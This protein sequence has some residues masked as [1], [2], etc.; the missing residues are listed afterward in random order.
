MAE[1]VYEQLPVGA[2]ME[3]DRV[4]QVKSAISRLDWGALRD[5]AILV[6]MMM[7]DDRIYADLNT[8][9]AGLLSSS[10]IVEPGP[11]ANKRARAAADDL[12]E[13]W[14]H[15]FSPSSLWSLHA[16]GTMLG[17]GI[18]QL[19]YSTVDGQ[20]RPRLQV[21]HPQFLY[22]QWSTK[23]YHLATANAG[24]IELPRVDENLHRDGQWVIYTPYG[25][26]LGYMRAALRYLAMPW[27]I[28]QWAYRDWARYSEVHGMP[29]RVAQTPSEF[30]I[31]PRKKFL[32]DISNL[33][34]ETALEAPKNKDGSAFD[35]KLVEAMG[36]SV[37]CF[38]RLLERCEKSIGIGLLGQDSSGRAQGGSLAQFK[39]DIR[40]DIVE[41][42][43]KR[44]MSTL[45]DQA[46]YWYTVHNDG[47]PLNVPTPHLDVAPPDDELEES[48]AL[49]NLFQA[50]QAGINTGLPIDWF[51]IL[52]TNGVPI[53]DDLA[54]Q[55][56]PPAVQIAQGGTPGEEPSSG[57]EP[58]APGG[59]KKGAA[60]PEPGTEGTAKKAQPAE[61]ALR[62]IGLT[63]TCIQLGRVTTKDSPPAGRCLF[64]GLPVTVENERGSI[65]R[66]GDLDG[67]QTVMKHHYGYLEEHLGADGEEVDC[68][69]GPNED[70]GWAYVIRQRDPSTGNYDEDKV[71]LG[72][73]SEAEAKDAYMQQYND[74]RFYGGMQ[75]MTMAE[76]K[77]K[78]KARKSRPGPIRLSE[79]VQLAE[80]ARPAF[81]TKRLAMYKGVNTSG[82][83]A[84]LGTKGRARG[85]QAMAVDLAGVLEDV[86][87]AKGFDDLKSRLKRRY[88]GMNP[89]KLATVLSNT[90]VLAN[91]AG[92]HDILADLVKPP[93]HVQH[94]ELT[95]PDADDD[96]KGGR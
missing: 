68:Y 6:D 71:M 47:D 17:V 45:K 22:W 27:L 64:Q 8:R 14:E 40:Q 92:R 70:A 51:A 88:A 18:G 66:W 5:A 26:E 93:R 96:E 69:L 20:W 35:L 85:K 83:A 89:E 95:E 9:C 42:D 25:Y 38:D 90:I 46:V 7:K 24:I 87:T 61:K 75:A 54:L 15:I 31:K 55:V 65:R 59:K 41:N 62:E 32:R 58:S 11:K 52:D 94:T 37:D 84:R 78:L 57:G 73:D 12:E 13:N 77:S 86:R 53:T 91:L 1:T 79:L 34:A 49:L 30:D 48:Q 76:F 67:E 81:G 29:I 19:L 63:D 44:L 23:S 21:W 50:I 33:A 16:W 82:Y 36:D 72:F 74:P 10:L 43:E 3:W 80:R 4:A 28:R 2:F 60:P 39:G 56:Q